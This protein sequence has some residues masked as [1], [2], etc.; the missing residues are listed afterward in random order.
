MINALHVR[1]EVVEFLLE[2]VL[3]AF[4]TSLTQKMK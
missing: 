4:I 3:P 2:Q 1:A